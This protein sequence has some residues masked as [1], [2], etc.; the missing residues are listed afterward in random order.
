[1]AE[2]LCLYV[3]VQ[4]N[5]ESSITHFLISFSPT[6]SSTFQPLA[7]KALPGHRVDHSFNPELLS[8]YF[9]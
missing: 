7:S 6:L 4:L 3:S 2:H 1:M 8:G 9:G 5:G